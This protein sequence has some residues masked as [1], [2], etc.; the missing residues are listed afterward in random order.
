ML[1]KNQ[2]EILAK[3]NSETNKQLA[4]YKKM[5]ERLETEIRKVLKTTEDTKS[6]VQTVYS[7]RLSEKEV[8]L[9]SCQ[10]DLK[11]KSTELKELRA[12]AQMILDQRSDVE[13]FFLEALE[14]V[15]VE[16]KKTKLEQREKTKL[17][18][19]KNKIKSTQFSL[20]TEDPYSHRLKKLE[21]EKIDIRELTWEEKEKVLR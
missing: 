6:D 18:L 12:L 3:K 5:N 7:E 4:L 9:L 14:R 10:E 1:V 20:V 8:Q 13:V 15:K 11:A 19:I 21:E 17:P 2:T 16:M